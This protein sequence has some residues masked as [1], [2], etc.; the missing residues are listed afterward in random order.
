VRKNIMV[1]RQPNLSC[2]QAFMPRPMIW[3]TTEE[4]DR[5]DCHAAC[6]L[7]ALAS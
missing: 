3:P 4:F 2:V 5:P 1:G 6:T 7:S